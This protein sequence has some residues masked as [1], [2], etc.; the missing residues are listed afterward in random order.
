[1]GCRK[2]IDCVEVVLLQDCVIVVGVWWNV[3]DMPFSVVQAV[4]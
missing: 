2:V 3:V 1:M 4:L